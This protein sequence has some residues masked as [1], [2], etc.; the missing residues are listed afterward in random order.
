MTNHN[1]SLWS[2][3]ALLIAVVTVTVGVGVPISAEAAK[4]SQPDQKKIK[5][6]K[7]EEGRL[8]KMDPSYKKQAN[9][10][11]K[12]YKKAAALVT[13]RGGDPKPLLDAAAYFDNEAK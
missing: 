5:V 3:P 1:Y 4:I 7:E 13:S 10:Q 11:A 8:K 6:Q 2:L 12:Q 9:T